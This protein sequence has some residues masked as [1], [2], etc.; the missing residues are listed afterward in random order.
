ML[1]T[2]QNEGPVAETPVSA[3][4]KNQQPILPSKKSETWFKDL[5]NQVQEEATQKFKDQNLNDPKIN[6]EYK[7]WARE[8]LLERAAHIEA[9]EI[10]QRIS[11]EETKVAN[12]K[13]T[14]RTLETEGSDPKKILGTPMTKLDPTLSKLPKLEAENSLLHK[15]V[16]ENNRSSLG[17]IK[18]EPKEINIAIKGNS[19]CFET[20]KVNV[21]IS[22]SGVLKVEANKIGG[23]VKDLS[24]SFTK[25]YLGNDNI[26][27]DENGNKISN[28]RSA[29]GNLASS[30]VPNLI[31][32]NRKDNEILD[33]H[34]KFLNNFSHEG[35][36]IIFVSGNPKNETKETTEAAQETLEVKNQKLENLQSTETSKSSKQIP[37]TKHIYHEN[38]NGVWQSKDAY[39]RLNKS[40]DREILEVY[41]GRDK[42]GKEIWT[43]ATRTNKPGFTLVLRSRS[44]GNLTRENGSE[45]SEF[46]KL[47]GTKLPTKAVSGIVDNTQSELKGLKNTSL[48]DILIDGKRPIFIDK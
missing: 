21:S 47:D 31:S 24:S 6:A 43:D 32:G 5:A 25:L 13:E 1:S 40:T 11:A 34:S 17:S 45:I 15:V 10:K 29:T 3:S 37:W 23:Q 9:N 7:A 2:N 48:N 35:K 27:R 16:S 38:V 22:A 26:L 12:L 20:L 39:V 46:S 14:I 36:Q 41:Q 33:V 4:D 19:N 44:T 30:F 28:I 8:T 18:I 42:E